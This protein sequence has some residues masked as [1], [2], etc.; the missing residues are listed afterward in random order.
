MVYKTGFSK[1]F[2]WVKSIDQNC[3]NDSTFEANEYRSDNNNPTII[4]IK[5]QSNKQ[6]KKFQ[7]LGTFTYQ[8]KIH[9]S[10]KF[11]LIYKNNH[12]FRALFDYIQ[13]RTKKKNLV[14]QKI[15]ITPLYLFKKKD[16]IETK[17]KLLKVVDHDIKKFQQDNRI[18]KNMKAFVDCLE[19]YSYEKTKYF[20]KCISYNNNYIDK[21]EHSSKGREDYN[22]FPNEHRCNKLCKI[23]NLKKISN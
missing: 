4:R 11:K 20:F 21:F 18:H 14:Y 8:Q 22:N 17:Y 12:K 13:D 23:F 7:I 6:E 10:K 16:Q 3:L 15:K 5:T 19:H 9:F 2:V 1:K